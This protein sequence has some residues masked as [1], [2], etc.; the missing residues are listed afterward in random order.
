MS[1]A[2]YDALKRSELVREYEAAFR[3]ATGMTLSLVPS[4]VPAKRIAIGHHENP[5]CALMAESAGSCEACLKIQAEAQRRAGTKFVPHEV[6]CF[7]GL[8]DVTVPVVVDGRHV[9]T[10]FGGQVF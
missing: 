2:A 9:A 4:G 3:A 6:C 10:L 1:S 8:T 7:A 5:F